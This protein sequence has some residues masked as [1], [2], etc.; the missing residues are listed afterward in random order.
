MAQSSSLTLNAKICALI[1]DTECTKR[2]TSLDTADCGS[3]NDRAVRINWGQPTGSWACENQ[4]K[5]KGSV[6]NNYVTCSDAKAACNAF[7]QAG[8]MP[9]KTIPH[10][11]R[12]K[13]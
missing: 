4:A 11:N 1:V 12:G 5:K 13:M 10:R 2:N 3:F 6:G 7:T 9:T 8:K